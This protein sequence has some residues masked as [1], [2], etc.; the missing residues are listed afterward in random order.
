M[1]NKQQIRQE[2]KLLKRSISAKQ[3][4]CLSREIA[5]AIEQLPGFEQA[6][7]IM[8]YH[9]LPDEVD[10]TPLLSKWAK[11]KSLYLPVVK[12]EELIISPYD[13][14]AVKKGAFG[15]WEPADERPIDPRTIE[16][17]VVPGVAFDLRRNRLGRGKG[18]YDKLLG[19]TQA[20]KIGIG[21]D[22]QLLDE[23]PAEPHDIKMD[24]V[25][26][27]KRIIHL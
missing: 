22:L 17:I 10:T 23:I 27:E 21:Y 6:E 20:V 16:W 3:R 12:G 24:I 4:E 26:T 1:N 9:A 8:L 7:H 25:V 18:Y 2:I 14:H 5:A 11:E 19:Q 15:I 13:P